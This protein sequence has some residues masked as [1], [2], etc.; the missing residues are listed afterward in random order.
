MQ[1]S[2]RPARRMLVATAAVLGLAACGGEMVV[3]PGDPAVYERIEAATD[4]HALREEVEQY[5]GSRVDDGELREA[6][7]AYALAGRARMKEL[8][9]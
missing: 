2:S 3:K 6:H 1:G 7:V 4:C 5:V 8:G 9:C